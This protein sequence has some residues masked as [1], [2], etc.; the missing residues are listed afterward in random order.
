MEEEILVCSL[1]CPHI[2]H[3]RKTIS[4]LVKGIAMLI[5]ILENEKDKLSLDTADKLA[6]FRKG[7]EAELLHISEAEREG[8]DYGELEF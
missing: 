1:N 2:Q 8:V 4:S 6:V 5:S 3:Y 7:L